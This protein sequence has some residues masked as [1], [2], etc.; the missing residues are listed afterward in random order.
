MSDISRMGKEGWYGCI[1]TFSPGFSSGSFHKDIPFPT[2]QLPY[3]LTHFAHREMT[4]ECT[5][6]IE[7]LRKRIQRRFFGREAPIQ[8]SKDLWEL[9]ELI[10]A[11]S[12]KAWG[13]TS[14]QQWGYK[15]CEQAS[16]EIRVQLDVIEQRIK[17]ARPT[18]SPKTLE[19]LNLMTRAITDIRSYCN[20]KKS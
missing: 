8:L 19:G 13:V 9:R 20:K 14:S 6:T 2:D 10:R 12:S 7:E 4:W 16:P 3:I 11:A 5:L 1:S 18:A 15:G 17:Q